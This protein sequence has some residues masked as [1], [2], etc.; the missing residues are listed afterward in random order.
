M[1][2]NH[3]HQSVINQIE[4]RLVIKKNGNYLTKGDCNIDFGPR[5]DESSPNRALDTNRH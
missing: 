1:L 2:N 5:V 3:F 4:S